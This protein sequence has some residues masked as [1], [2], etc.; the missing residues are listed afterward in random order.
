MTDTAPAAAREPRRGREARARARAQR[1]SPPSPTS[2]ATF[3]SPR[4]SARRGS[5]S[6]S[7]TPRPCL[8]E[9]GVEFRDFPVALEL[10]RAAGGD[11]KG[12][13]VRFPSGLARKLCA[14]TPRNMCSTRA[15]PSATSHR[16]QGDGVRA[17]L[18][19]ALRSRSR[20]GPP[21]RHDRGLPQF[22][23][24]RLR[25]A[26]T[27]TI[28]AARC[29]SR[30]I[31]RSTSGISRW[32]TR[33]CTYSDKPFMG[34][35]TNPERARDTVA[36]CE[37]LFGKDFVASNTVCTSLINANSPL[38]WDS[39]HARRGGGLRARQSGLHHHARSSCPAR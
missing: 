7:A 27:S 3:R 9:V 39:T 16:R 30:S 4:W 32:S 34:S 33:I 23:E 14:T 6:S 38:V 12:E 20:Q 17:Q 15:I 8:Q 35:V 10:F 11:I 19:L 28:P 18:R 37:I 1:R 24:A 22:R 29:A 25:V 36:M 2:P 13:R 21:L 5:R 31:C 26:R